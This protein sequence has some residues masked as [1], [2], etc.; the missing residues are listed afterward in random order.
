MNA[1]DRFQH[2][3]KLASYQV[4]NHDMYSMASPRHQVE[5]SNVKNALTVGAGL[6]GAKLT[7]SLARPFSDKAAPLGSQK[8]RNIATLGAGWYAAK[9]AKDYLSPKQNGSM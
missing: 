4:Q 7:H 1:V 2:Y 3:I 9:K 5:S 6:A 8:F